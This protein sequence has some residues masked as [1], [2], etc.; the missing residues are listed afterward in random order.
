MDRRRCVS[1]RHR[2][3]GPHK[4]VVGGFRSARAVPSLPPRH[5]LCLSAAVYAF[6]F[7][8]AAKGGE[9]CPMALPLPLNNFESDAAMRRGTIK[10]KYVMASRAVRKYHFRPRK[11]GNIV[12]DTAVE[13]EI[14]AM[15]PAALP[16]AL[17]GNRDR[18]ASAP[19]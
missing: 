16:R 5:C 17:A 2:H 10:L 11:A 9:T 8:R 12:S 18:A 13:T 15:P 7:N 14:A 3:V 19:D 4:S 6:L 1:A